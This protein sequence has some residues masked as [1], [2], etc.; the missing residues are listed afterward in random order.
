MTIDIEIEELKRKFQQFIRDALIAE[1]ERLQAIAKVVD[2]SADECKKELEIMQEKL[3]QAEEQ[4]EQLKGALTN[5]I[6]E[7]RL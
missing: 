2:A 5:N 1:M 7:D 3:R 4:I 6:L